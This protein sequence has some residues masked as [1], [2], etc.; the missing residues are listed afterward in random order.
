M[1]IKPITDRTLV[2][3]TTVN[4]EFQTNQKGLLELGDER[5]SPTKISRSIWIYIELESWN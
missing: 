4:R 2:D 5:P 3:K 1:A